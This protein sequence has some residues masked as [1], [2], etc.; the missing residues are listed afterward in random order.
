MPSP[1]L[2]PLDGPFLPYVGLGE[3]PERGPGSEGIHS[4]QARPYSVRAGGGSGN[5]AQCCRALQ[6][7]AINEGT[8]PVLIC[9]VK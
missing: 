6:G 1:H 5:A 2:T 8:A 7:A 4:V 3:V 9:N